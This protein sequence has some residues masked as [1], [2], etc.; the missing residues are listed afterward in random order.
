[1]RMASIIGL[2]AVCISY[3]VYASPFAATWDEVDFALA[4]DRYDLLAMQ[5]HFPGYPYFILGGMLIHSFVDNAAKAL[6][7]WN[8]LLMM[9]ATIPM[10]LLAKTYVEQKYALVVTA[11]VQSLSYVMLIVSQ[12]MSEGS[13][14]AI[15]WWYV[16]S[17][18]RALHSDHLYVQLLPLWLFSV[19]LGIRLSYIPFGIGILYVW[20]KRTYRLKQLF[21][22]SLAALAFQFIWIFAVAATE[23]DGFWQLAFSF[24]TGHFTQWGG[25]VSTDEA[26][27]WQRV[28]VLIFYNIIWTGM[29]KQSIWLL[30][31]FVVLLLITW[32]RILIPPLYRFLLVVYFFWALFAQNIEKPR[33]ILPLVVIVS[34]FLFVG[35][36]Q[37]SS[38]LH[39]T[40]VLV[41][42]FSQTVIGMQAVKHQ[43]TQLP[44]T[45]QLAYDFEQKEEPFVLFTWEET[46]VLEY[47]R[48]SF[49]HERVFSFDAFQR[50]KAAF[51][52]VKVY[53]TDHV[54]KGFQAQ[55]INVRPYIR[56]TRTYE[57]SLLSDPVYGRITVYEWR[58][59]EKRE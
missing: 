57:S 52:H 21:L 1:M 12:P 50:E 26:P 11:L 48:V 9:S 44:A 59:E 46:R 19:M 30:S 3:I 13:A 35:A 51:P 28:V 7:I 6:A 32:K 18:E 22:Y 31:C 10:Y 36:L 34:F 49:P 56:P 16:W 25:T 41:L 54:I 47:L 40:V 55:G 39:L 45:Y 23:G 14:L 15:L 58:E 5:P 38:R 37:S 4:L 27:F 20:W 24:T 17:L 43:A 33:H 42:L 29:A 8:G 53:V 2:F